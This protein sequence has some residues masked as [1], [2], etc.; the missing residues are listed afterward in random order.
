MVKINNKTYCDSNDCIH[1]RGCLR[2]FDFQNGNF[3]KCVF[4][5]YD[6]NCMD[7]GFKFLVRFR[8]SDGSEMK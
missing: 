4:L 5:V 1:R 6:T 3:K 7:N 8:L 2:H